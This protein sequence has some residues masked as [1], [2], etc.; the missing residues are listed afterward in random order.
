MARDRRSTESDNTPMVARWGTGHPSAPLVVALHG[1]GTSEH[2]MIE[3]APWLPHGPVAYLAVRAPIEGDSGFI[4]FDESGPDDLA[5]TTR[6]LL[7]WLETEGDPDRP[8]LLLGFRDGV[9]VAGAMMLEAPD[10]F[11]G[12]VLLYGALPDGP[13]TSLVR[14]RLAG[15][16]VFL[17]HGTGD[18]RTPTDRLLSTWSWLSTQSG[19]PLWA[20]RGPGGAQLAGDVVGHAGTWLGDRL[21]HLRAHGENPLP[22]GDEPDWPIGRLPERVG[23]PPKV[24]TVTPQHQE[25]QNA[26]A[27]LQAEL[28]K[29]VVALDGVS[30]AP[31]TVGVAGTRSLLLDREHAEGPDAAFVLPAEGEFA[32]LHPESDG[33][34][35]VALPDAL[36]Y[37]ALAKGWAVA[38]PLAGV[39]VSAGMVLVPG[40]RDEGEVEIVAGIVAASHRFA[41]AG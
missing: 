12:A 14:G 20:E 7:D 2:S 37:D 11:A 10:R 5:G 34:L 31:A 6:W 25:S 18:T 33:S 29:R 22:D 13:A 19:A 8:I 16:P 39:R 40:P 24:T 4:W 9:T 41:A 38:H 1:N 15:M 36:A 30:T 23:P 17:A 27:H 32:H 26:P 28:W 35:H 21:D 3:I